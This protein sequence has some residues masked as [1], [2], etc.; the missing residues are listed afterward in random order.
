MRVE[1]TLPALQAVSIE[2]GADA[3]ALIET[4]SALLI[5]L[6]ANTLRQGTEVSSRRLQS[7]RDG[8]GLQATVRAQLE[9]LP[10]K[11]D[12]LFGG[13]YV[14]LSNR[15]GT[16][17]AP[18]SLSTD[19]AKLGVSLNEKP[20]FHWS[21]RVIKDGT[22]ELAHQGVSVNQSHDYYE[23]LAQVPGS[24]VT[25]ETIYT[26]AG[27]IRV[28]G[29]HD[30]DGKKYAEVSINQNWHLGRDVI[31]TKQ[32]VDAAVAALDAATYQSATEI[33]AA[34]SHL[35]DLSDRLR[36]MVDYSDSYLGAGREARDYRQEQ[37][38]DTRISTVLEQIL[39][40]TEER[41]RRSAAGE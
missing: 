17:D 38:L 23:E 7:L 31:A 16:G 26:F 25:A 36:E 2:Q 10:V 9:D 39:R 30:S 6:M 37:Q 40:R 3:G 41:N 5:D 29:L 4:L 27:A 13:E 34:F 11:Q 28:Y 33:S 12:V 14:H 20:A 32:E 35:A 22:S 18:E 15:S 21:I 1:S 24:D 19:L 8:V